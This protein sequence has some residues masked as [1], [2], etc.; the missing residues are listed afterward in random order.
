MVMLQAFNGAGDT[1]TPTYV[2]LFGFWILEL[3]LAWWL[4]IHTRFGVNG[5]FVSVVV[6]QIAIV[7]ISIGLFRQGRWARQRI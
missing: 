3:P 1:L 2:N 5:V 7:L 6:A 4:A